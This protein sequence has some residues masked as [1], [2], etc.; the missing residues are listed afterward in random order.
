MSFRPEGYKRSVRRCG[1]EGYLPYNGHPHVN[2]HVRDSIV[3]YLQR[4]S[5]PVTSAE[6]AGALTYSPSYMR[7]AMRWMTADGMLLR[8]VG[9]NG[10]VN[11]YDLPKPPTDGDDSLTKQCA[12]CHSVYPLSAFQRDRSQKS[13]RHSRCR[14]CRSPRSDKNAVTMYREVVP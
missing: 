2:E 14:W 4:M 1:P 10:T 12:K 3:D 6:V 9:G 7:N 5:R 13:G 8:V 11:L